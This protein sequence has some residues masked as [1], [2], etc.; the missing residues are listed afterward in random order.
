MRA[1]L[2]L[3][4]QFRVVHCGKLS[5]AG[6]IEHADQARTP[7]GQGH[8]GERTA[9]GVEFGRRVVMRPRVR[10]IERQ[11]RLRISALCGFDAGRGAAQ[12]APAVGADD[13]LYPCFAI[14]V[15]DR[16]AG[17]IARDREG[18][19]SKARQFQRG[20]ARFERG[21]QMP[22]LDV[23]AEGVETDLGRGKQDFRRAN[24][25]LGGID[26][27]DF[28]KRRGVRHAGRPH[29]E[30]FQRRDRTGK[31]RRGTVIRL[32][33]RRDQERIDAGRCQRDGRN[34][35]GRPAADD[36]YLGAECVAHAVRAF[37]LRS[38]V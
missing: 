4:R 7:A 37:D 24:K 10:Q 18:R 32:G 31:Q 11:R 27:A 22:V 36:R 21:D 30:R 20:S 38:K 26:E 6:G 29:T 28:A 5:G 13:E 3:A 25:P 1:A 14:G 23:V 35:A 34:Q 16:H 15:F 33:R 12:R 2:D 8:E 19:T 9:F 17:S